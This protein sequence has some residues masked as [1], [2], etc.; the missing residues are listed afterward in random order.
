MRERIPNFA[1]CLALLGV[2]DCGRS[3]PSFEQATIQPSV[4]I[5]MAGME[6]AIEAGRMPKVGVHIDGAKVEYTHMPLSQL[7]A[8]AYKVK[9]YQVEGP[10]WL[11]TERFDIVARLPGGASRDDAP[12]MLESLLEQRFRLSVRRQKA[13]YPVLALELGEGGLKLKKSPQ[14]PM[15]IDEHEALKPGEISLDGSEGPARM[16]MDPVTGAAAID[17]GIRGKMTYRM[18]PDTHSMHIE[19]SMVTMTGLAG[20]LTQLFSLVRD[21]GARWRIVDMTGIAGSYEAALDIPRADLTGMAKS[22]GLDASDADSAGEKTAGMPAKN[23]DPREASVTEA[24]QSLGLRLEPSRAMVERLIVLR[25]EKA[26]I[27]E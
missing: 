27:V 17:M 6:S 12:Q 26:P 14:A 25:A 13:M 9:P 21:D 23:S 7:V 2:V 15:P 3:K 8:V 5:D 24:V 10:L 4:T 20:M 11:S 22:A 18:D 16:R 1:L 19:F